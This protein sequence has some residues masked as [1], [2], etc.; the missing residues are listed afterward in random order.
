MEE[1]RS[2]VITC[3]NDDPPTI[4]TISETVKEIK[5]SSV[6]KVHNL[7]GVHLS[8]DIS[9]LFVTGINGCL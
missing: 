2:L 9:S 7:L 1:L 8:C 5:Q 3:L 6:S 4:V